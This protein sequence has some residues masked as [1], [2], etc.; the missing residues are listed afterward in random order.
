MRIT[1][2]NKYEIFDQFIRAKLDAEQIS[3]LSDQIIQDSALSIEFNL[4]MELYQVYQFS[5]HEKNL[6]ATFV[7]L[8]TST[9]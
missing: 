3:K 7:K 2:D 8:Q 1:E 4:M 9:I 6:K 5:I